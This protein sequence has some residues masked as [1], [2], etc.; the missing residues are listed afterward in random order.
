MW[1]TE[2]GGSER[3]APPPGG[4]V[5]S[6]WKN[7]VLPC[8]G[9]TDLHY[10]KNGY[11][12]SS[13]PELVSRRH[14]LTLRLRRRQRRWPAEATRPLSSGLN[15]VCLKPSMW[16]SPKCF[17]MPPAG[18]VVQICG[19]VTV[20]WAG[21]GRGGPPAGRTGMPWASDGGCPSCSSRQ[22]SST[23]PRFQCGMA[24]RIMIGGAAASG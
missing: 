23:R 13:R 6:I 16:Y 2:N 10:G 14:D 1:T 7:H 5:R 21:P 19:A 4:P 20:G 24:R 8:S 15:S 18:S 11:V 12:P 3:A 22:E 9:S 17:P